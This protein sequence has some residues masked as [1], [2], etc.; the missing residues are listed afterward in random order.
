MFQHPRAKWVRR[1]MRIAALFLGAAAVMAQS[2]EAFDLNEQALRAAEQGDQAAAERLYHRAIDIW[3]SLG[4]DYQA[5]LGTTEYNLGQTLCA[6]GR[7]AEALPLVDHGLELL[8]ATLG[9]RHTNTLHAM[10]YVA[11]LRL[12]LGDAAGA[13][14]LFREALPVERELFPK[15]TQ[16]ALTLGGL[17]SIL[18]RQNKAAEALPLA[19]EQLRIAIEAAGEQSL[20]AA[21]AYGNVATVHKW[22]RRYDLALPLYRKS[23][24]IYEHL[25]GPEHPR[26]ASVLSEIG[27][28]EMED[29]NYTLAERD[30]KQA[31]DILGRP[32]GWNVEQWIGETNLGILRFREAKYAEAARWLESSLRLQEEAGIR[33]GD[34]AVTLETL[35]KVREKQ[36]RF[37]DA[38]QLHERAAM[39]SAYR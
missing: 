33:E 14:A 35:A 9:L 25:V 7:R 2:R 38:R 27:L 37:D 1:L 20:D 11:G 31:L 8:R 26:T 28:M 36:R 6:L 22:G 5:H 32:P 16:L 17:S 19:E 4:P 18:V 29:G 24:S 13:E 10:N 3:R 12:M 23:L 39:V 21:L 34:L 30:M 15:D